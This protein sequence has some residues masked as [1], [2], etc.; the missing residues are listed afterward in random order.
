MSAPPEITPVAPAPGE[1]VDPK[2]C[3]IQVS[4]A[5]THTEV[6]FPTVIGSQHYLQL[7][8]GTLTVR[9]C[10]SKF[11]MAACQ[12]RALNDDCRAPVLHQNEEHGAATGVMSVIHA[13]ASICTFMFM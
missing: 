3:L 9:G 12:L 6:E 4:R 11:T 2:T 8:G 10:S 5:R 13:S 1:V 7:N